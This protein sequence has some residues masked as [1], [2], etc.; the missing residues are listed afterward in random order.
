MLIGQA[1]GVHVG[2]DDVHRDHGVAS[3]RMSEGR[4]PWVC[5]FVQTVVCQ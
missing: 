3:G 1:V 2:A 4:V 5:V